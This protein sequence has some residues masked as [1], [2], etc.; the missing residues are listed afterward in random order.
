ML[1]SR[2]EGTVASLTDLYL[3][4]MNP[5]QEKKTPDVR[6][7]SNYVRALD[8]GIE[9]LR[10]APFSLTVLKELHAIL[11]EGVRGSDKSPGAFRQRQNFI[12]RTDRIQDATYLPPPHEHVLGLLERLEGF[13]N[14]THRIPLLVRLAMIHDQFEAIHPFEDGNGRVGRL[15]I[16]IL[17]DRERALPHP[18]LY[19]SAFF[20]R[21][22][23]AYYNLLLKVSQEGDWNAWI[24]FFLRGVADQSIDAVE[25][26]QALFALRDRWMAGCQKALRIGPARQAGRHALHQPVSQRSSRRGRARGATP[27]GAE[28]HRPAHQPGH[29]RRDHRPAAEPRVCRKRDHPRP[30]GIARVR[31]P[32]AGASHMSRVR[33]GDEYK[34]LLVDLYARTHEALCAN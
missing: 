26:S 27:V 2:I 1:S 25:R 15:L 4:E 11:L 33:L 14:G 7:V 20:E 28:E 13:V 5:E 21:H 22:Q 8:H 30:G 19:L 34:A 32:P 3:F 10:C 17:L 18:V 9:R 12:S 23:R 6:E 24:G 31:R 16:S 29:P